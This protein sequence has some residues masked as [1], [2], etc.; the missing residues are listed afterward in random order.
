MTL[1]ITKVDLMKRIRV[2][3]INKKFIGFLEGVYEYEDGNPSKY[4]FK[5]VEYDTVE[6]FKKRNKE[7]TLVEIK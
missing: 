2:I 1:N 5:G 6:D 7:F 3:D 4:K